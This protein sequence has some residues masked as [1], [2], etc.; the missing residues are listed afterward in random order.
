M[1]E[2][3][4]SLPDYLQKVLDLDSSMV[5]NGGSKN[6]RLFFRGHSNK[7]Y[8]IVPNI[9]RGKREAAQ[10]GLLDEE[11]NLVEMAKNKLPGI[12][13][14]SLQPIELLALL[15]HHG[16]PTRLL[17][18]TENPLVALYFAVSG[19]EDKD[20]EVIA[21]KTNELSIVTYPVINAIAESYKYAKATT[22]PLSFFYKSVIQQPYFLE[23]RSAL[24]YK[25]DKAGGDWIASC[26]RDPIYVCSAINSQRQQMQQG[27]YILFPNRISSLDQEAA[28]FFEKVIDPIN[29]D[30]KC[31][32]ERFI[33]CKDKKELIRRNLDLIGINKERLF[34]D[35]IDIVCQ[36][37]LEE[38]K[39]RISP[40]V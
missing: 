31:I 33:I 2:M 32:A 21:F 22:I 12:F 9:G 29:K 3:I 24:E 18:I 19:N 15:Q 35:S 11:R 23:Q 27:R 20:G 17:D 37:I 1:I 8:E 7:A 14:S 34:C 40:Y 30:N 38:S 5:R 13:T 4:Q 10:I 28:P 26:C 39:K 6:E 25:N 16:I 36:G